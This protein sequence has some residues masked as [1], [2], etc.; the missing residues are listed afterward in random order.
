MPPKWSKDF[1]K[2]HEE[3]IDWVLTQFKG[4]NSA[5]LE[6]ASTIIYS[7]REAV[8]KSESL[9]IDVLTQRIQQI[10]PRF[11]EAQ[12]RSTILDLR[13]RGLLSAVTSQE[14]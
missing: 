1:L 2:R 12:I 14:L 8:A 3:D 4:L 9:S 10:K 6:L 11:N 5:L 13:R 7:D